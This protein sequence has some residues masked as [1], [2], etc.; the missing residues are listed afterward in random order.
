MVFANHLSCFPSCKE[1]LPIPIHHVQLWTAELDA[2]QGAIKCSQV[3]STLYYLTL[4]GLPNCLKQVLRIAQHF[5]DTWDE[6]SLKDSILLK[7]NCIC[8][9][10][11]L[12]NCTLADL[13]GANQGMEKMQAEVREAVYWPSISADI[14][15]YVCRCTI[16]TKHKASQPMLPQD[17]PDSPWQEIA[18]D[19]F[20]Q[21][22]KEYLLICNLLSKYPFLFRISSKSTYSLSQKLQGLIF[23]YGPCSHI[24]TDNSPPFMSDEFTQFL[25]WQHI[26]HTTSFQHFPRSNSFTEQQVMTLKTALSTT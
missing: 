14:A 8:I 15:D 3:N 16:C 1:S 26:D 5:W 9:P 21:R 25:Q 13:H 6:L 19:Y 7:G 12:L 20:H 10:I 2:I 17:I 4:R 11:E 24:Y 23:Q 18:A 22:S